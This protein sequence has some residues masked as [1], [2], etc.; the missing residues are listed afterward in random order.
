M[1]EQEVTIRNNNLL[2]LFSG[3]NNDLLVLK[4]WKGAL[5]WIMPELLGLLQN[6]N[7]AL[8]PL[9]IIYIKALKLRH[10]PIYNSFPVT[11]QHII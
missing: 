3:Y 9:V 6:N 11:D 10:Y 5:N 7:L 1:E 2:F 8:R 4:L